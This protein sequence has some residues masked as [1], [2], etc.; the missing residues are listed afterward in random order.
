MK[1]SGNLGLKSHYCNEKHIIF[2]LVPKS[3]KK[4][5]GVKTGSELKRCCR[6]DTTKDRTQFCGHN[7]IAPIE[8]HRAELWTKFPDKK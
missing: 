7:T 3:K 8:T 5:H 1:H 2:L 4:N 6:G